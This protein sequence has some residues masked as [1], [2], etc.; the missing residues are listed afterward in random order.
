MTQAP[1]PTGYTNYQTPPPAKPMGLAVTSMILGILSIPIC[2]LW[3][4]SAPLGIVA[5]VLGIMAKN[6]ADRGE[7]GGRGM[8][9]TGIITGAIGALLAI[10]LLLIG[11]FGGEAI[12]QRVRIWEQDLQRQ[13]DQQ[14]QRDI[15]MEQEPVEPVDPATP[16]PPTETEPM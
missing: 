16:P 4:I 10:T 2:C 15:E 8:A 12:Q 6:A 13:V 14:E 3:F 11:L 1:P 5:I 9:L 7:A